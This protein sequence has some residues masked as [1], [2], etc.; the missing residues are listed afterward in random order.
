MC[1]IGHKY[2][3]DLS[4]RHLS[5]NL[6]MSQPSGIVDSRLTG[7]LSFHVQQVSTLTKE[8]ISSLVSFPLLIT[9]VKNVLGQK[10]FVVSS[11]GKKGTLVYLLSTN[12]GYPLLVY[13]FVRFMTTCMAK[14]LL[15]AGPYFE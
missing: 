12:K 10:L 6:G 14:S 3:H 5:L 11:S 9:M 8:G 4:S 15:A 1:H 13:G 2:K 7:F